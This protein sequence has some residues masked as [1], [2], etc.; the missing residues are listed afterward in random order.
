MCSTEQARLRWI[1]IVHRGMLILA[2]HS[3]SLAPLRMIP[4]DYASFVLTAYPAMFAFRM[5]HVSGALWRPARKARR[6]PCCRRRATYFRR[7]QWQDFLRHRD[8]RSRWRGWQGNSCYCSSQRISF[9]PLYPWLIQLRL[10]MCIIS[11]P[12]KGW[13]SH[14][15]P[16]RCCWDTG[17]SPGAAATAGLR[18][19]IR[20]PPRRSRLRDTISIRRA[21]IGLITNIR[22]PPR[23]CGFR[24]I[25]G[26][27]RATIGLTTNIRAPP[28][29]CTLRDAVGIRRATVGLATSIRAPPRQCRLRGAVGVRRATV[30]LTTNIGAPPRRFGSRDAVGVRR[31]AVG[32][33]AGIGAPRIRRATISPSLG[34][35]PPRCH[36][37]NPHA[38]TSSRTIILWMLITRFA[39]IGWISNLWMMRCCRRLARRLTCCRALL[40]QHLVWRMHD[41]RPTWCWQIIAHCPSRSPRRRRLI[42]SKFATA[43]V[44][45]N[46]GDTG[47]IP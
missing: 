42:S 37:V 29:R 35:A 40:G 17:C 46:N 33:T 31:A 9:S 27:R 14:W 18:T 12:T 36:D 32:L 43:H 5:I 30:G 21:T 24:G 10:P 45:D 11:G 26:V 16:R 23:R 47:C 19:M 15:T 4:M 34:V 3:F 22:A 2:P 39:A 8:L 7:L 13:R 6:A 38:A 25:V 41:R 28:R 1:I 20:A 44:V